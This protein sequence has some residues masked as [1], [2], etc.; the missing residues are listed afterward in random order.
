MSDEHAQPNSV[1]AVDFGSVTT[2]A[3]LFALANGRYRMVAHA[4]APTTSGPPFGDVGEGLRHTL[5]E[6]TRTTGRV[7]LSELD[8]LLVPERA[9]GVGADEFLA[10]ASGGRPMRAVLVGLVPEISLESARRASAATYMTIE[11]AIS[12]ADPRSENAQIDAIITLAPDVVFIVGGTD[13]GAED[14]V[15]NLA[16]RVSVALSLMEQGRRPRVL[17][18][19]N[20]ALGF[21]V[22]EMF[23]GQTETHI[24]QNVR[25]SLAEETLDAAQTRLGVVYDGFKASSAGGFREISQVSRIGVLPTSQGFSRLLGFL[26]AVARENGGAPRPVLG[27][28]VGGATTV[29]ATAWEDM[30]PIS[31]RSD[32]GLGQSAVTAFEAIGAENI[33]RWLSYR[34]DP[35]DVRDYAWNKWLRPGTAPQSEADLELELAFAREVIRTA[36]EGARGMWRRLP[37]KGALL[38]AFDPILLSGAVFGEAAHPGHAAL[39]LLD[40]LQPHGVMRVMLDPY[41]LAPALGAAAYRAPL[42][43]VQTLQAGDLPQLG[44]IIAPLGRLKE[45]DTA[46]RIRVRVGETVSDY[47]VRAGSLRL[48]PI[49]ADR[50]DVIV[51]PHRRLDLGRGRGRQVNLRVQGAWPA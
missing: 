17:F 9:P 50:A 2:R 27:V 14:A 24:A 25:P 48:I 5:S 15:L 28:D 4:K 46:L 16:R 1:L 40:A 23:G 47:G 37:R 39:L 43:V 13:G 3:V 51:R 10:T 49:E 42:V 35:E 6:V 31:V 18:A 41:G 26:A 33:M 44:T 11:D 8:Q 34:L 7:M 36:L 29:L 20:A 30:T 32:L 45:G 12:L 22:Q 19:G 38:P 21:Q